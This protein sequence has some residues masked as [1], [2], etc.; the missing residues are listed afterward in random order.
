MFQR[1]YLFFSFLFF[2]TVTQGNIAFSFKLGCADFYNKFLPLFLSS[3]YVLEGAWGQW[4]WDLHVSN[5]KH[6]SFDVLV[7]LPLCEAFNKY[8]AI[9]NN[10]NELSKWFK[11][12]ETESRIVVAQGEGKIEIGIVILWVESSHFPR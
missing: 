6:T 9:K 5:I 11:F 10:D 12:I 7:P 1:D 2:F 3:I 4:K 8:L